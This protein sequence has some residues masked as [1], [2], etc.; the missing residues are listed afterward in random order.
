MRSDRAQSLIEFALA[1]PIVLLVVLGTFDA[2]RAAWQLNA[3]GYAAREGARYAIAHGAV[4]E[5]PV[6]P[7]PL[8]DAAIQET[9]RR[10]SVGLPMPTVTVT[11]PDGDNTGGSRVTVEAT[12]QY[13]PV[14][15]SYLAGGAFR[16][17]LHG[18][19]T[20]VIR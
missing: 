2:A 18:A 15:S 12:I 14:V 5:A 10:A 3:I 20:Q 1:V 4:S 19:T 6:G 9:V 11:W 8:S 7:P 17:T 13:A 16:L